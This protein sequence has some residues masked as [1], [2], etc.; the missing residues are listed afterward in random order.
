MK[1]AIACTEPLSSMSLP[2]RAP[3]RNSGKNWARK[4]AAPPMKVWVQWASRGSAAAAAA[5]SA[6]AGASRR[7]LQ[8]R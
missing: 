2:N 7:M 1:R 6:A 3:R 4:R 8:P 5:T